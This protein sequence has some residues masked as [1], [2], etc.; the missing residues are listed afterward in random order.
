[1]NPTPE[2]DPAWLTECEH[3]PK[4][5]LRPEA[6]QRSLEAALAA[7]TSAQRMTPTG[8]HRLRKFVN[9]H[10]VGWAACWI[11]AGIL[12]LQAPPSAAK[13]DSS[14][15]VIGPIYPQSMPQDPE[16]EKIIASLYPQRTDG[17]FYSFGPPILTK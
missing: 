14:E 1:M 12:W 11:T 5:T 4:P 10:T 7:M 15:A 8:K 6:R 13:I 3:L 9:F 17:G 2:S 16:M